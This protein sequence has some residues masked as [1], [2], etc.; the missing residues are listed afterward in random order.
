MSACLLVCFSHSSLHSPLSCTSRSPLLLYSLALSFPFSA[1][2]S[3]LSAVALRSCSLLFLLSIPQLNPSPQLLLPNTNAIRTQTQFAC[4]TNANAIRMQHKRNS[5]ADKRNADKH[6]SH[7]DKRNSQ[8]DKTKHNSYADKH[9]QHE[10]NLHTDKHTADKHN[11]HAKKRMHS[12]ADKRNADKR[13]SQ[14]DKPKHNSHADKLMQNERNLHTDK[15]NTDK[16]NSHTDK[17]MH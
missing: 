1:L 17:H 11:S 7:A 12:H 14:A 9:M 10:R 15:H 6:N 3:L 2:L 13:T 16:H 8:A 4:N 5:H